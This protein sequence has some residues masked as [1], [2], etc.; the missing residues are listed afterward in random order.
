MIAELLTQNNLLWSKKK[1]NSNDFGIK[2]VYICFEEFAADVTT[3]E[4]AGFLLGSIGLVLLQRGLRRNQ[5]IIL[6]DLTE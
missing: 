4:K 1:S 5:E 3:N 6:L 2:I